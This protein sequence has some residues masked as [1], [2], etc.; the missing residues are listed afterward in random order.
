MAPTRGSVRV[1]GVDAPRRRPRAAPPGDR[2]GVPGELPLRRHR[3]REPHAR[4]RRRRR[5]GP[6][7]ARRR[8]G[9]P[10]SSERLPHG[11]DEVVGERGV[12]LSGGQRQR[13]A[14]ARALLR[15]PARP[16]PRRRHLRGRPDGRASRSSTGCG[17]GGRHHDRRRPPRVDDRAGRPGAAP[18]RRAHRRRR[19]PRRAARPSPRTPR[20]SAPTNRTPREPWTKSLGERDDTDA[21]LDVLTDA[22]PP[23]SHDHERRRPGALRGGGRAPRRRRHRGAAPGP[24]RHARAAAGRRAH[25][26]AG[27]GHRARE[28]GRPDP[29]PADPRPRRPRRRRLPA[30]LRGRRL[31]GHGGAH[32]RALRRQP[33][34][35]P[36]PRAGGRGQPARAARPHLRAHPPPVARRPRR[37][38][39]G[40]A[41]VPRHQRRRDDGPVH[42]VGRGG[43]DRRL[44]PDRGDLRGDGRVLV[45][46]RARDRR[47]VRAARAD[48]A[49]LQRRQLRGL[50][51]GADARSAAPCRRSPSS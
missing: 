1:G 39:A 16:P 37:A 7:G 6:R 23:G 43:V 11:L 3:P 46:A 30:R 8:S 5:R 49:S 42:R 48:P 13:L 4:R 27:G 15:R 28:A 10:P 18:R 26:P 21:D 41:R 24:G 36:P 9:P 34:D 40:R 51:R 50:R 20:S 35:L 25:R 2:A 19:H 44:G 38:A 17:R 33:G 31:R 45:A 14:L 12:T 22:A 47:R 29:D 32:P